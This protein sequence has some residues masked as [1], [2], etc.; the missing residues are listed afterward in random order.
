[1]HMKNLGKWTRS[2]P[3]AYKDN[4]V[5]SHARANNEKGF[6]PSY[7]SE[8]RPNMYCLLNFEYRRIWFKERGQYEKEVYTKK[9]M[10]KE[11]SKIKRRFVQRMMIPKRQEKRLPII[12]FKRKSMAENIKN[13]VKK[14]TIV[15]FTKSRSPHCKKA[16]D[17]FDSMNKSYV[18]I[19]LD[20]RKDGKEMQYELEKITGARTIPRIFIK[21]ECVGGS[22]D[23][24]NLYDEGK[25]KD[26][27]QKS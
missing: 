20:L 16:K 9:E 17:L 27:I 24:Q 1:M 3:I 11:E 7:E 5:S 19:D 10:M 23:L 13:L 18:S 22:A 21:G 14:D 15:M 6:V 4:I 26:M 25:L 2:V 12:E 8:G